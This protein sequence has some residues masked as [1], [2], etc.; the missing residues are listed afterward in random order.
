MSDVSKR[1]TEYTGLMSETCSEKERA[2]EKGRDLP[3]FRSFEATLLLN[4]VVAN[5]NVLI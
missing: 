3:S 5:F 2:K 1:T 4:E